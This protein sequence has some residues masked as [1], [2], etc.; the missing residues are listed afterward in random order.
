MTDRVVNQLLTQMDGAEGLSGVYVLAATSRPDLIDSALLRPGRLDKSLL[1][2]L[3]DEDDRVDILVA[4]AREGKI[5]IEDEGEGGWA[6][7]W[8]KKTP[9]FSGADLQALVYNAHLE[10][11]HEGIEATA[12]ANGG[13]DG[14]EDDGEA[15]GPLEF[16]EVVGSSSS[17]GDDASTSTSTRRSGAE[18]QALR[19]RLELALTNS[20]AQQHQRPGRRAAPAVNG[21]AAASEFASNTVAA[22]GHRLVTS[23][24]LSRSLAGLRPSVPEAERVRLA[25][26]YREFAGGKERGEEGFASG[27]GSRE[28]GARESLM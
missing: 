2:D 16:A 26:I 11:V 24:H 13:N 7:Q 6:R 25:R 4:V 12:A 28:V 14:G 1:C 18:E 27:E 22:R 20:R 5:E 10:V 8:A 9:G 23:A 17:S 21:E 3:P 19:R 15:G